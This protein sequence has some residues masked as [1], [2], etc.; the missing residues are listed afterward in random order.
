MP[1]YRSWSETEIQSSRFGINGNWKEYWNESPNFSNKFLTENLHEKHFE[2]LTLLNWT[3]LLRRATACTGG[4]FVIRQTV[5][6]LSML[7][8]LFIASSVT[9]RG[10]ML[11]P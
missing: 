4:N 11:T 5:I 3:R 7:S 1:R 9:A 10:K 6:L 2:S 8:S